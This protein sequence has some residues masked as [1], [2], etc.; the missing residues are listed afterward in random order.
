MFS[1]IIISKE[2]TWPFELWRIFQTKSETSQAYAYYLAKWL[3]GVV[4]QLGQYQLLECYTEELKE[5]EVT[6]LFM[7][8]CV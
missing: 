1:Y 6:G 4:Q 2:N 8:K 7:F 5:D 3:D